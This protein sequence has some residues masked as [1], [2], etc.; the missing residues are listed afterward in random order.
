MSDAWKDAIAVWTEPRY[1]SAARVV[2]R[3]VFAFA[4]VFVE[5]VAVQQEWL[6]LAI[7]LG[8]GAFA[9]GLH[10]TLAVANLAINKGVIL[11]YTP[12][13]VLEWPQSIQERVLKRPADFVDG[14]IIS[15]VLD[16]PVNIPSLHKPRVTLVGSTKEMKAVPLYGQKPTVLVDRMN[17]V[18]ESRGVHA[19]LGRTLDH[20]RF[21][22][23]QA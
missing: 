10:A 5:F 8:F 16:K 23:P 17:E 22:G 2:L 4:W 20:E 11:R 9:T 6:W 7:P 3:S 12:S 1:I 18:L 14:R 13:G 21:E 15:V 19:K